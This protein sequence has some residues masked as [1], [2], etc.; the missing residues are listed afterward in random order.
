MFVVCS[1]D[2]M[3]PGINKMNVYHGRHNNSVMTNQQLQLFVKIADTGSFTKAG[4]ELNLTQ[5]AVS[6]AMSSLETEMGVK[7]LIRDRRNGILLT[8][9]GK[10]ILVLFRDILQS[11]EKVDQEIAQEKGLDIGTVRV[12]AFPVA[13]SYFLP[14]IMSVITEKYPQLEFELHEG[15]IDEIKD[16]LDKRVVDV[17]LIIPP[18]GDL[19]TI[20][21]FREKMYA[22]IREGHPLQD[23]SVIAVK[24]LSHDSMIMCRSGYESPIVDLYRRAD[25][26]LQARFVVRNVNTALN[27]VQEGLGTAILSQLSLWALPPNVL[28]RELEPEAFRDIRLAVPSRSDTSIAVNLFIET[29]LKLFGGDQGGG[30]I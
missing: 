13:S 25:T 7:L 6:R 17:G 14:K 24:D 29:A 9:V 16:W 15:T 30:N 18:D 5:P 4:Q 28:V 12:G 1:H 20:P 8:D 19:D 23:C 22:V 3:H 11:F 2:T 27:M 26:K 10:R 21:L